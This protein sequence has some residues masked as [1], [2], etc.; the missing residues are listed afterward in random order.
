[1]KFLV[2]PGADLCISPRKLVR[3]KFAKTPYVLSAANGSDLRYSYPIAEPRTS[4]RLS[5]EI[6]DCGCV[7]C[8]HRSEF[9]G[10]L[11]SP[12]RRAEPAV[13]RPDDVADGA[14]KR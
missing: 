11:Q 4:A 9:L 14:C 10:T 7:T 2:D 8:N 13:N 6:R 3:G 12:R 1:M 5:L